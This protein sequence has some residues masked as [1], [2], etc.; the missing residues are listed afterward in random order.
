MSAWIRRSPRRPS[1]RHQLAWSFAA[2]ALAVAFAQ[3]ALVWFTGYRA[4]E[5]IID[6]ITAEQ[7][8][9]SIAQYR[10]DPAL[11]QPNTPDMRLYVAADGDRSA[12]P[13]FLR[14]LPQAAGSHELF[15]GGGI[16]YHVAVARDGEHW[17]YLAYDVA[18]HDRRQQNVLAVL[19]ASVPAI[20]LLVLVVG[21]GL[22]RRLT[23]D[24]ER[25]SLAVRGESARGRGTELAA[26]A[27]HAE[28]ADLAMAL[29]DQRH[30][31]DAA[32][33]RE[34]AFSAAASHE[35]RTPLMRAGSTLELLRATCLDEQQRIRVEQLGASLTE[36]TMLTAGLLRVAR[37]G[38]RDAGAAIDL[39][40]LATDVAAHLEAE[41]RARS[42]VVSTQGPPGVNVIGDRDALWIVLV[43]LL[44]NAIRH[45]GGA[46]VSVDWGD[47]AL[48]ISDDGRGFDVGRASD[49][50][51]P[52]VGGTDDRAGDG[53][54][55]HGLGLSIVER[56]C[57]ASAW[58]L[59]LD[60]VPGRG[61]RA[62]ITIA[63]VGE[64]GDERSG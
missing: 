63:Q 15:P 23:A 56:I 31:L 42:I 60:S 5:A 4:E 36:I 47:G 17:F 45:S 59:A 7:L 11:A 3:A 50:R 64:P 2:L 57:E 58:R 49:A 26:L 29:D 53:E 24:L 16:E 46:R 39:R 21:S 19:T 14:S 34:R 52:G 10:R 44:R 9:L 38:T 22:A 6:D 18:E 25:L 62:T 61:T 33:V 8:R 55:G 1:L 32:L 35:L 20:A 41:A 27:R 54:G 48:T 13:D 12:L 40:A 37:G 28:S 51:R 43:N 30:R